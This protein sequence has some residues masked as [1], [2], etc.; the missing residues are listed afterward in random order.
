M[1][2]REAFDFRGSVVACPLLSIIMFECLFTGL[3]EP[4]Q[5]AGQAVPVA[6]H[7]RAL[8]PAQAGGLEACHQVGTLFQCC[9]SGSAWIRN[10]FLDPKLFVS[11]PVPAKIQITN[12]KSNFLL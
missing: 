2:P 11:N 9:E 10:F 6:V 1:K 3:C 8:S 4:V 5:W 7:C 12:K